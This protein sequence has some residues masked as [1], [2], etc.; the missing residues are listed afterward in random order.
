MLHINP[1]HQL[2]VQASEVPCGSNCQHYPA[3]P[4]GPGCP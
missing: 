1:T 2:H 4:V 3:V